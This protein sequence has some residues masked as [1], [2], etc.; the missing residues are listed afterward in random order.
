MASRSHLSRRNRA[1]AQAIAASDAKRGP[2]Q[3]LLALL[4]LAGLIAS[5]LLG[6]TLFGNTLFGNT[7]LGTGL[8]LTNP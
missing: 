3:M 4:M 6:N 5:A 1:Q 2:L 8:L 7:L